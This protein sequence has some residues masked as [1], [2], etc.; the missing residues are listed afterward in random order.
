MLFSQFVALVAIS[1]INNLL[2]LISIWNIV[3]FNLTI[4]TNVQVTQ[5]FKQKFIETTSY[6]NYKWNTTNNYIFHLSKGMSLM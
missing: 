4:S 3:L 5:D 1:Y 2:I 6:L